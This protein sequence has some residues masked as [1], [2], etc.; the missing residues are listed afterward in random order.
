M[1]RIVH[2]NVKENI[3]VSY[4]PHTDEY[5]VED[6]RRTPTAYT[7]LPSWLLDELYNESW[8]SDV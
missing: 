4:D 6:K 5:L 3:T 2:Q 7:R 8:E 1:S